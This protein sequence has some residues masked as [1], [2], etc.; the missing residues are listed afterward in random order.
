MNKTTCLI[1]PY[2]KFIR[3]CRA[4]VP[5]GTRMSQLAL[6]RCQQL[7][8]SLMEQT[9]QMAYQFTINC[10]RKYVTETDLGRGI[11]AMEKFAFLPRTHMTGL[12]GQGKFCAGQAPKAPKPRKTRLGRTQWK[13]PVPPC[14]AAYGMM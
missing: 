12:V 8:E 11:S 5:D 7:I 3:V 1:L 6:E 14:W 2:T 10:G 4:I 9:L 13:Y